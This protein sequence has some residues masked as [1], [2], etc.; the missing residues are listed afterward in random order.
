M[1]NHL[2]KESQLDLLIR[3]YKELAYSVMEAE[4]S[5]DGKQ[6]THESQWCISQQV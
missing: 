6:V 2:E 4:I 3:F 1:E 5:Q